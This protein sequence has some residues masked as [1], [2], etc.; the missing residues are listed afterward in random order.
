M[1]IGYAG[2][3]YAIVWTFGLGGFATPESIAPLAGRLGWTI[4]DPARFVPLY[5]IFTGISA[6]VVSTA[7]GLGEEIGWR[8]FMT[9]LLYDKFGFMGGTLV[10][11]II[12]TAWHVPLILFSNYNNGTPPL[13]A[14][15]CFFIMIVNTSVIMTWLR[16]RSGSV[17]PCA[18]LHGSHNLFIQ[19]IFTPLT[20]ERGS[21]T[22][23]AIDEFGFMLPVAGFIF[24]LIFWLNR[25][26]AIAAYDARRARG[27]I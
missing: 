6:I 9:P 27:L 26:K 8:G 4:T 10:T 15:T 2:L 14:L 17:W 12:W 24:A 25:D 18:I 13:F 1:P 3:A 16:L 19:M 21:I 23:Y 20:S 5:F 11:G 7:H 22:A